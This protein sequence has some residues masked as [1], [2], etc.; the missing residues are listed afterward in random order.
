MV[1]SNE[2]FKKMI[3]LFLLIDYYN[4]Y[5]IFFK[6]YIGLSLFFFLLCVIYFRVFEEWINLW[7]VNLMK[8]RFFKCLFLNYK[9]LN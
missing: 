3:L 5:C 6:K 7:L 1:F 9:I 8:E 2:S 4:S